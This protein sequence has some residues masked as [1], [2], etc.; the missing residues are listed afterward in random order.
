[1]I[2]ALISWIRGLRRRRSLESEMR[3]EMRQHLEHRIDEH[4]QNGLTKKEAT[5]AAAIEFGPIVSWEEEARTARGWDWIDRGL[6]NL[7][8]A[9]RQLEHGKL[10]SLV[11]AG[12]LSLFLGLNAAAFTVLNALVLHPLPFPHSDR[13]VEV[14]NSFPKVGIP[15]FTSNIG[16]F[17]DFK[18]NVPAFE[19]A[20]LWEEKQDALVDNRH[21]KLLV[22]AEVT[23]DFFDLLSIHPV[24]GRFFVDSDDRANAPR[25]VVITESFWNSQFSRQPD[26][27][28]KALRLNGESFEIVGVA[29]RAF[30]N[31]SP[32]VK[33]LRP[34]IWDSSQFMQRTGFSSMLIARLKPAYSLAQAQI[35]TTAREKTFYNHAPAQNRSFID[36]TGQTVCLDLLSHQR[37]LQFEHP[38]F[39]LQVAAFAVFLIAVANVIN[40]FVARINAREAE[41][42]VRAALGASKA[43]IIFQLAV[44]A[45]VISAL[46]LIGGFAVATTALKITNSFIA[47]LAPNLVSFEL[48]PHAVFAAVALTVLL[49]ALLTAITSSHA[50]GQSSEFSNEV[51]LRTHSASKRR[52]RLAGIFIT[53]QIA[54]ALMI[55]VAAT[56]L[57]FSFWR[58]QSV[59][60]GFNAEHLLSLHIA[61]PLSK[62]KTLPAALDEALGKLPGMESC[63]VTTTPFYLVPPTNV[64]APLARIFFPGDHPAIV[65]SL[66]STY[67]VGVTRN[68]AE[69][70]GIQMLRGHWF[71][72]QEIADDK[73]VVI[74][75]KLW[76]RYFPGEDPI[77]KRIALN[78]NPPPNGSGWL[79]IIGVAQ[80]V[81]QNGVIDKTDQPF[82]YMSRT[83]APFF[84]SASI[85]VKTQRDPAEA[86]QLLR[87]TVAALDSQIPT[88]DDKPLRA[89]MAD[90]I[91]DRRSMMML[92]V[93]L[94]G[95]SVLLA[96][97]GIYGS[98][99]YDISCRTREIGIRTAIGATRSDVVKLIVNQTRRRAAIG[100]LIGLS[101]CLLS[102]RFIEN[103]LFN[104]SSIDAASYLGSASIVFL[105]CIVA[106]LVPGIH[107]SRLNPSVALRAE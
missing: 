44:E 81:M 66:P 9:R 5:R 95:A 52:R 4:V 83:H 49:T 86:L 82:A 87:S 15:K 18:A 67:Y 42:H 29:P 105:T 99:S 72:A 59:S 68:Y 16:Q 12:S 6:R 1:M 88:Y 70:L 43:D 35:Q 38:L 76:K 19:D 65:D 80:N 60:P 26:V 39:L 17:I 102:H 54:F 25:V 75:E 71:T 50:L 55:S 57:T 103:L 58:A 41:F 64:S 94:A 53:G 85:L 40:L 63:V 73:T 107:A 47:V 37:A 78:R 69:L 96:S 13:V 79:E 21:S 7:R 46:G 98:L 14:Y 104:I 22:T 28:G 36:Q 74:D 101:G 31:F 8:Y 48:S 61:L 92:L 97:L 3:E 91:Q 45:G 27:V 84:G 23:A 106:G 93:A 34:M 90:S 32:Q 10:F 24:L 33:A 11:T 51:S 2:A 89:V 20:A 30:E 56:L 77:G 100:V 62:E